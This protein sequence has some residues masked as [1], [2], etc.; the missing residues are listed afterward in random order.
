[1]KKGY[2]F[3]ALRKSNYRRAK[4]HLMPVR[5]RN[6]QHPMKR[7]N[8]TAALDHKRA[9]K[10]R[11]VRVVAVFYDHISWWSNSKVEKRRWK[12]TEKPNLSTDSLVMQT[13][14]IALLKIQ[15]VTSR[16]RKLL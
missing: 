15:K 13:A 2:T 1:M 4:Q 14:K 8:A 3:C 12:L 6:Q 7:N 10:K 5:P 16:V 9:W 11:A